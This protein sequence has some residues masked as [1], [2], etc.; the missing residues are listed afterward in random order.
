[1]RLSENDI[2]ALILIA[3]SEEPM[4]PRVLLAERRGREVVLAGTPPAETFKTLYFSPQGLTCRRFCL[5]GGAR[6]I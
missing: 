1:M 5:S 4:K 3:G 6:K 2:R